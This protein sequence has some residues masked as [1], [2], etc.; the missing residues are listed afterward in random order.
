MH[1]LDHA[2]DHLDGAWAEDGGS[3]AW[4]Q[5]EAR[6]YHREALVIDAV[7]GG[8]LLPA[9]TKLA[10]RE[11][12]RPLQQMDLARL[13]STTYDG[14][15]PGASSEV[16][17]SEFERDTRAVALGFGAVLATACHPTSLADVADVSQHS[18]VVRAAAKTWGFDVSTG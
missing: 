14:V 6:A 11:S 10:E 7:A 17:A 9:L 8:R 5:A 18:A 16:P 2:L 12:S 3:D 1:E 4:W 15:F 13:G